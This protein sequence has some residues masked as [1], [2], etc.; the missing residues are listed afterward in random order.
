V[1][2]FLT[3]LRDAVDAAVAAGPIVVAPEIADFVRALDPES[4]SDEDF[5]GLLAAVGMTGSPDHIAGG[6][7]GLPESMAEINALLDLASP[8][9]REA[10]LT[11]FLDRLTRPRRR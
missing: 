2:E 7:V 8:P 5:D 3:A 1:D 11:A 10:L 6:G 9:L 4:L